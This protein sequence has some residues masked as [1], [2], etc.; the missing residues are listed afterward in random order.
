[1]AQK[2]QYDRKKANMFG[3]STGPLNRKTTLAQNGQLSLEQMNL[4]RG[5]NDFNAGSG[6]YDPSFI[7]Q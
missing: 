2:Q 3:T 7:Y 6:G 5:D 1:M 4:D